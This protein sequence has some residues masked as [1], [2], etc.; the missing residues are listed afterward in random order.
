MAKAQTSTRGS[1]FKDMTQEP[2]CGCLRAIKQA[3]KSRSGVIL[4]ECLCDKSLGGCGAT[5]IVRG[6]HLRSGH[7]QSCGCLAELVQKTC[8]VTHGMTKTPEYQSWHGMKQ[9][10]T[11]SRH[12]S[13]SD[14]GGR[15]I[16]VC[17]RWM[18]FE[19]FLSD[20]GRKPSTSHSIDRI[21]NNGNYEPSNC[22][23]ASKESQARNNRRNR[24]LTI[25]E[26]T[27]LISDWARETGLSV[28]T[29]C[30]RL[31]RGWTTERAVS[32]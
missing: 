17:D 8:H 28:A 20:M 19:N 15:G 12:T 21:D 13:F 29:I 3:G 16:S 23:W 7:T 6:I 30:K 5:T 4:W 14:Y 11:N 10:C 1:R 25:G 31:A 27:Q 18:T 24:P 26:R 2:P 32:P 9:R 22:V